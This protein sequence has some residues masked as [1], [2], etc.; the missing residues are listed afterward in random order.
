VAAACDGGVCG[1]APEPVGV[2]CSLGE[3]DG[4][5]ACVECLADSDCLSGVC[6]AGELPEGDGLLRVD[7]RAADLGRRTGP[8]RH[9]RANHEIRIEDGE[10]ALEVAAAQCRQEGI[11]HLTLP[12]EIGFG[13]LRAAAHAASRAAGELAR[14]RFGTAEDRRD[15]LERRGEHIVQ[16]EG[17]AFRGR[18]PVEHDEQRKPY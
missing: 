7:R 4:Q 14:R 5:G 15:F 10:Q 2:A 1:Q 12:G 11:D 17:Q 9:V 6:E 16:H 3:C 18:E 8:G 13:R